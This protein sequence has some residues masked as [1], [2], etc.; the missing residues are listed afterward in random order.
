[1]KMMV[2]ILAQVNPIAKMRSRDVSKISV[3]M[4]RLRH[5]LLS[6]KRLA[7]SIHTIHRPLARTQSVPIPNAFKPNAKMKRVDLEDVSSEDD[8]ENDFEDTPRIAVAIP[9][10]FAKVSTTAEESLEQENG[11]P[12]PTIRLHR[13]MHLAEKLKQ[14]FELEDIHEVLTGLRIFFLLFGTSCS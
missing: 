6:V 1:M 2:M 3:F 9:S 11:A 14:V 5:F 7:S 13:R 12:L 4:K 10:Q 8:I